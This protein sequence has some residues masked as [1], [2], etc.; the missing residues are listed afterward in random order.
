MTEENTPAAAE[1]TDSSLFTQHGKASLLE[2]YIDITDL[3][4][5]ARNAKNNMRTHLMFNYIG[6]EAY[7]ADFFKF[8]GNLYDATCFEV[9]QT[10]SKINK[11]DEVFTDEWKKRIETFFAKDFN[12]KD[13]DELRDMAKE[14]ILLHDYYERLLGLSGFRKV[15]F[16]ALNEEEL[17]RK[18]F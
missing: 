12:A 13:Y 1:R 8:F 7:V 9:E 14:G 2:Q 15:S 16:F 11:R 17:W 6:L 3:R 10:K 18:N 4:M 5:Q